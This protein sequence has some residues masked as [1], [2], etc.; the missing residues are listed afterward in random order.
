VGALLD[1]SQALARR[2]SPHEV[3]SRADTGKRVAHP[4][5]GL[6]VLDCQ[7]LTAENRR[8]GLP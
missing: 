1:E 8:A 6:F 2:R 7:A 4:L 3:R 5:A